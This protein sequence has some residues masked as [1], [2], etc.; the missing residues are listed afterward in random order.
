MSNNENVS[1]AWAGFKSLWLIIAILLFLFLL[2]TWLL[3]YGPGGKNCAVAPTV[4]EKPVMIMDK[5][6]PKIGVKGSSVVNMM[7]GERFTDAGYMALDNK[8]S[9]VNVVVSGKVDTKTPGEYILTYTA[10]DAAGNKSVETRKVIV[11]A[12]DK[13]T[14]GPRLSL[15]GSSRAM[16][17]AGSKYVD[18]GASAMDSVDGETSI[19]VTGKVDTNVPGTYTLVYTSTDTAG[20]TS[21][22]KRT[23]IVEAPLA[24][25]KLYFE[26]GSAEFP[27]DT[28]LSLATVIAQLRK[29]SGAQAIVSG[30]HDKSGNAALNKELSYNRAIS[31]RDLLQQSGITADRIV[32]QKPALTTGTGSPRE[33]RRVEV[34]VRK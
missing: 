32:L 25:A 14:V 7:V 34:R 16:I 10:T 22:V 30:F 20:N 3:G 26:V 6:A 12:S 5:I 8:D 4:V 2:I 27:A 11:S 33:A 31:V 13:D 17:P 21:T 18:I 15:I 19:K 9:S 24:V 23:V 1:P 29:N 28:E